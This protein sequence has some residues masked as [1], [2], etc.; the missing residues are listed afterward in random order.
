MSI[1]TWKQE[2]YP[3]KARSDMSDLEA[4]EHAIKKFTGTLRENLEKH[5]LR[6]HYGSVTSSI[7]ETPGFIFSSDNCAF[8]LKYLDR[9]DEGGR[10]SKCPLKTIRKI[11]CDLPS[12]EGPWG[13]FIKE[14]NPKPMLEL[15]NK[16]KEFLLKK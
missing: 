12:K 1:E 11:P 2:F 16:V 3:E 9:Y 8:C 13:K 6:L 7:L 4:C 10:C 15:L 14:D 5:G